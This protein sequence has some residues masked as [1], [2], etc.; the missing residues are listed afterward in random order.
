MFVCTCFSSKIL[1]NINSFF[2]ELTKKLYLILCPLIISTFSWGQKGVLILG[3]CH[4][5]GNWRISHHK[6]I[7]STELGRKIK[8]FR[9]KKNFTLPLLRFTQRRSRNKLFQFIHPQ[10]VCLSDP[11]LR[12]RCWKNTGNL[13]V[14]NPP[15]PKI[16]TFSLR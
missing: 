6:I 8:N 14:R 13:F 2:F 7:K 11:C 3:K 15:F 16:G 4:S 5:S 9:R 1:R 10:C 12:Y